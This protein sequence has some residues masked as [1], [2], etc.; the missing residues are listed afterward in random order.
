MQIANHTFFI[1]G[2]SS[3]LGAATASLLAERHAN[4]VIVDLNS[5]DGSLLVN[6]IG[7]KAFFIQADVTQEK[8]V[9]AALS[10][11]VK[12]F[13]KLHGVINCAGV[14]GTEKIINKS[15]VHNYESFKR[16]INVNLLGTFNVIRLA[17]ELM[18]QN[19]PSLS[20]ERGI[21]INTS[22][23]AAYE[24]QIGQAAYSA[25]KAAI[26]GMTLPIA[27]E[28]AKYGIRVVSIAPG[29]FDTPMMQNL[30]EDVRNSLGA[31]VPF[32][33]RLGRPSEF[34]ELAAHIVENELLNGTVIR[35]DGAI[36]MGPK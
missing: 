31:Q 35:L 1:T 18:S 7:S 19:I 36:R 11:T 10:E 9:N 28:L 23:I 22:S 34:A 12:K 25:S 29:I 13:G 21:I 3:G 2:G 24:G 8:D 16:T 20:Q 4:V 17:A 5:N 27:R 32:P 30:S 14:L 15:G 26:N 33:S 6:R